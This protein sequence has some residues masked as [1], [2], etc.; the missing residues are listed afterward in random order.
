M[1]RTEN[2]M[3]GERQFTR[4]YSDE[5][6][7]VVRDGIEYTEANDPADLGRTYA[8]GDLMPPEEVAAQA[9]AILNIIL[10]GGET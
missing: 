3:I 6:R 5:N 2:Y 7:Y 9:E 10:G 8:E 4:T 1:I